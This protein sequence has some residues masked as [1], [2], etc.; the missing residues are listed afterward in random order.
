MRLLRPLLAI[1][2]LSLTLPLSAATSEIYVDEKPH[3]VEGSGYFT[4][5]I[6]DF[7]TKDKEG[8][9]FWF[10]LHPG[11]SLTMDVGLLNATLRIETAAG[12]E[13]PAT[14][15]FTN[16]NKKNATISSQTSH[17]EFLRADGKSDGTLVLDSNSW[18]EY[19]YSETKK[20]ASTPLWRPKSLKVN[21]N[22]TFAA[23]LPVEA[24][25]KAYVDETFTIPSGCTFRLEAYSE[26][27]NQLPEIAFTDET[28]TL[29]FALGDNV[30]AS[31]ESLEL[32]EKY[33]KLL[34]SSPNRF[35]FER[36]TTISPQLTFTDSPTLESNGARVVF[37]A[38]TQFDANHPS[39]I[40]K[41]SDA[42]LAFVKSSVFNGNSPSFIVEG[43]DAQLNFL[44]APKFNR[45]EPSFIIKDGGALQ[46]NHAHFSTV[47]IENGG[48]LNQLDALDCLTGFGLVDI[49]YETEFIDPIYTTINTIY[50]DSGNELSVTG[51]CIKDVQKITGSGTLLL[52]PVNTDSGYYGWAELDAAL[53]QGKFS[54]TFTSTAVTLF[55]DIDFTQIK[56]NTFDYI[57][58]PYI[59]SGI[60]DDAVIKIKIRLDQYDNMKFLWPTKKLN[61]ITFTL[62][63]S[64]SFPGTAT[65]PAF[66][67]ELKQFTF[68]RS[69]GETPIE[70]YSID[71]KNEIT[72]GTVIL[73]WDPS[74]PGFEGLRY[75][76]NKKLNEE[77]PEGKTPGTVIGK[78]STEATKA[79]ECFSG[80]YTFKEQENSDT[81]DLNVDYAFGIS[82]LTFVDGGKNILV[83][84][85]LS[86]NASASPKFLGKPTLSINGNPANVTPLTDE[87]ISERGLTAQ[88]GKDTR[89]FLIPYDSL[90]ASGDLTITVSAN[91]PQA[92]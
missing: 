6:K 76:V 18:T 57:F 42:Q 24:D 51:N 79:L 71:R 43:K 81:V 91:P 83:E 35:I 70:N 30:T 20:K 60:L 69:D 25:G 84:V 2:A 86:S 52:A 82:R 26:N 36:D 28:S 1:L 46:A 7:S 14:L 10:R 3:E 4:D 78:T 8:S 65:V 53:R 40:V 72:D 49:D 58:K 13:N 22:L 61:Q 63:E 17:I 59:P 92:N 64:G 56:E 90:P 73:T 15:I 54:G 34:T 62:I 74:P 19:K 41:G 39:F 16:K 80:I 29:V 27:P 48:K 47:T 37:S 77:I 5:H 31:D 66:S 32:P 88:D 75:D 68:L 87:E 38:P 44:T 12:P 23:P 33:R 50:V 67:D 21:C 11:A 45:S 9:L 55:T 85:T 89:W